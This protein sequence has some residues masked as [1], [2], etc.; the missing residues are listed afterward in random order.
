MTAQKIVD[1]KASY[2]SRKQR[3]CQAV[4]ELS[5]KVS[6]THRTVHMEII[7][8]DSRKAGVPINIKTSKNENV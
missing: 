4:Q 6:V 5:R 7:Y 2:N 1:L 8:M 3:F